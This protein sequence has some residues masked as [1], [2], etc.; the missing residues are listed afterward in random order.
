MV[1]NDDKGKRISI[2][3]EHGIYAR[4]KEECQGENAL[5]IYVNDCRNGCII[6]YKNVLHS[7]HGI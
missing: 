1:E 3:R 6:L 4:C 2:A 7:K 5:A